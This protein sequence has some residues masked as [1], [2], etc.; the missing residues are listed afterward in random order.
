M[1]AKR[2]SVSAW[3]RLLVG[4]SMIRTL[5]LMDEGAGDFHDLLLGRAAA[6]DRGVKRNVFVAQFR[7]RLPG[8][9]AAT[10]AVEPAEAR[11]LL[12][13]Q[14]VLLHAQVRS[15]R[16]LLVNHRHAAAP[17]VQGIGRDER[18]SVEFDRA[19][20][21]LMGAAEDLHQGA[22][23]RAVFADQDMHLAGGDFKGNIL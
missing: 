16:Q 23:T 20:V 8:Q 5:G 7:Q 11:R 19:G 10:G 4:S 12:A 14:D 3:V 15:Q 17:R 9:F 21:R 22:F 13:Q 2:F 18:P 1:T 6:A